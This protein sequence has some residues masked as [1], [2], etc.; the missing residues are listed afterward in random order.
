MYAYIG[1]SVFICKECNAYI[2]YEERI[3][4]SRRSV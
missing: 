2:W 1:D 4:K 3:N